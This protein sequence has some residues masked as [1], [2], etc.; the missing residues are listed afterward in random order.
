MRHKLRGR[1]LGRDT[2]HRIA[3]LRNQV[4]SLLNH[5]KIKTTLPKAKET[6]RV[7]ERLITRAKE[8]TPHNRRI[9]R[10]FLQDRK[11]TNKLFVEFAPLFKDRNGGYTRIY[12]LGFR[13]GDG[14]EMALLQLVSYPSERTKEK[15]KKEEEK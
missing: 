5:G 11:M 2:E 10:Q 9:V 12:R 15:G 1:R 6:R 13:R 7:V 8:D 3:L 4:L 14:A